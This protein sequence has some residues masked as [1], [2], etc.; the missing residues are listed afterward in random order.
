MVDKKINYSN[1]SAS[2][3]LK[4]AYQLKYFPVGIKFVQKGEEIFNLQKAKQ[5]NTICAFI[6][7][8]AQGKSFYLDKNCIS[9][10]GGLKWLGFHSK[11][12]KSFLYPLF[13]GEIEKVK[14]SSKIVKRFIETLPKPPREGLYEK[15]FF[16]PLQKCQ[17]EPDVVVLI[18]T[19]RH[20]YRIIVTTYLD[21]C[22]LVKITPL[23]AAC[24]GA[25]SIPFTT[26]ELNIS[27]IDPISREFGK[28]QEEDI[29]VGVPKKRFSLLINN[30]KKTPF[31]LKKEPLIT[32]TVEKLINYIPW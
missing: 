27:M 2:K 26:G 30:L 25:I 9:C 14:G 16:A 15:L 1:Q 28:Y 13:L 22:R 31:G 5:K 19:P 10:P 29:L 32:K 20:T 4:K 8:A 18:T 7:I 24:H 17:F 11:F 23:C 21:D 3:L 12:T 6:K